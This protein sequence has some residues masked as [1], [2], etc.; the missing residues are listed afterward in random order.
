MLG[1]S[2]GL[3][4]LVSTLIVSEKAWVVR[5]IDNVFLG[6]VLNLVFMLYFRMRVSQEEKAR[7]AAQEKQKKGKTKKKRNKLGRVETLRLIT[8]HFG[9]S[10]FV[11]FVLS[12]LGTVIYTLAK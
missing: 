3:A 8:T 12:G 1:I 11:L 9:W 10:S 4:M 5:V 6:A 7:S 2:I